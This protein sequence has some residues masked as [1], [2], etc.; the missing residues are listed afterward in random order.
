MKRRL[1]KRQTNIKIPEPLPKLEISD[2]P[3]GVW[4]GSIARLRLYASQP[5][6]VYAYKAPG[7]NDDFVGTTTDLNI[8][9]ALFSARD[10]GRPVWGYT[11]SDSIVWLD[12]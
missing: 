6:L 7:S 1:I 3:V 12:Y 5:G 8:T 11:D 10:N 2:T 4:Y 9:R